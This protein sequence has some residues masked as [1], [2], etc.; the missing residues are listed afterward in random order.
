[1]SDTSFFILHHAT[2]YLIVYVDDIIVTGPNPSHLQQCIQS[3]ANRFSP[4]DLGDLSY[5]LGVEVMPTPDG[6]FLSQQ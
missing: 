6:L 5:F 3:L 4:E 1:M 2:L